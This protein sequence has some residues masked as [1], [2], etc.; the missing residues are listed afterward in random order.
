MSYYFV[1]TINNNAIVARDESKFEVVI[2]GKGIGIS[3]SRIIGSA[4]NESLIERVFVTKNNNYL[5]SLLKDIPYLYL[6]VVQDIITDASRKLKFDFK[7]TLFL[8]ILDHIS[9]AKKRLEIGETIVNPLLNEIKTFH[10]KEYEAACDAINEINKKLNVQFDEN[11]AGFIAFHFVNA[12]SNLEQSQNKKI[13]IMMKDLL[14]YIESFEYIQLDKN[15]FYYNRLVTHIK[16]FLIRTIQNRKEERG[17]QKGE[18]IESIRIN[19][20]GEWECSIKIKEYLFSKYE[21]EVNE[22]ELA[23]LTMHILPMFKKR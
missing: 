1:K 10:V 17:E 20:M 3:T 18:F 16:Y 8:T 6:S 23:Y 21:I 5:E 14:E 22:Q 7:D 9:F 19:Y 11:E 13:V 12:M 4:I 15:S 2:L